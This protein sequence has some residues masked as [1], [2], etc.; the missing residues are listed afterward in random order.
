MT[1]ET[2]KDDEKECLV[3]RTGATLSL[4]LTLLAPRGAAHP[5]RTV[6]DYYLLLPSSYF[7]G[8]G[9]DTR[10]ER[11][12]LLKD[13][14][15]SYVDRAH[16]YLHIRGDGAQPDLNVCLFKRPDGSYL[17]AAGSTTDSDGQWDPEFDFF[18]YRQG[19]LVA[20]TRAI[21]PPGIDKRL[22]F[23]L[24]RYGTTI[25]VVNDR[26]KTVEYLYWNGSGFRARRAGR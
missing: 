5:P 20:V 22:G 13:F 11:L 15:G 8:L 3:D 26:G 12:R 2:E 16:G 1:G 7:A 6:V 21:R 25:R 4:L 19:R 23:V 24:P 18:T 17:V 14:K 10:S 9:T